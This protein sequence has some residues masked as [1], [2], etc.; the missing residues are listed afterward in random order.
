MFSHASCTWLEWFCNNWKKP[1]HFTHLWNAFR[2]WGKALYSH[3]LW[4]WRHWAQRGKRDTYKCKVRCAVSHE[5]FSLL[6]LWSYHLTGVQ[7]WTVT[8]SVEEYPACY[9]ILFFS[10]P[11]DLLVKNV[12]LETSENLWKHR[13]EDF[14]SSKT[15]VVRRGAPFKI[16]LRLEGRPLNPRTDSLRIKVLLGSLRWEIIKRDIVHN[17]TK[18]CLTKNDNG[19]N[20]NIVCNSGKREDGVAKSKWPAR[21]QKQNIDQWAHIH[22]C[23]Q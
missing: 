12:N 14:S 3:R 10:S 2:G 15:L 19:D 6:I 22:K 17:S 5:C 16:T 11:L 4:L 18:G 23:K 8:C 1:V 7:W 13:T 9:L 21:K 20:D